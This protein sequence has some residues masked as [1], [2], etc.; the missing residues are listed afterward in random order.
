MNIDFSYCESYNLE[1]CKSCKRNLNFY[2]V[3]NLNFWVLC[4]EI[5]NNNCLN[6]LLKI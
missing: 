5:E 3:D 2:I 1:E 6:Y 4:P